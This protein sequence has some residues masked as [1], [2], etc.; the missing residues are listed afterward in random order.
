MKITNQS[1]F[2]WKNSK[3]LIDIFQLCR[4][5]VLNIESNDYSEAGEQSRMFLT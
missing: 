3:A 5:T 4:Y 1:H 2:V